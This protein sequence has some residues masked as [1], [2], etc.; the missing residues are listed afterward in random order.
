MVVIGGYMLLRMVPSVGAQSSSS[1]YRIDESFIGS[2]GLID[3]NS[4]NYNLRASLG[5]TGIGNAGS[6]NYQVY[7]G[8]TT[9]S[10]EYIEV[11]VDGTPI[12]FGAINDQ[13]TATGT[14]TFY[15]RSYLAQG[16]SVFSSGSPP[17]SENGDVIEE[18]STLGAPTVGVEEFGFNLVANTSPTTF[19]AA[20]QQVPDNTFSFGY[21]ATG[22]NSANQFKYVEGQRIAQSDSSSG[23]TTY[24]I[25]YII[26]RAFLTPA[27]TYTMDHA[28]I[29]TATY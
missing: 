5:D 22:Y 29:A 19:G 27:G 2:G 12:D 20:P 21:V 28:I 13:S 11:F 23:Q 10:E 6:T 25:S 26:N 3:A 8:Y 1:N 16:Y 18:K 15:I 4:T 9:T 24:T 14:G 17:T 7:G